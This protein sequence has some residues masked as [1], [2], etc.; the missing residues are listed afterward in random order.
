MQ[1]DPRHV[2]FITFNC[3]IAFFRLFL[4]NKT[5]QPFSSPWP[6]LPSLPMTSLQGT[7]DKD[8]TDNIQSNNLFKPTLLA[9]AWKNI[10]VLKS[11]PKEL[12]NY[13]FPPGSVWYID[14]D[15]SCSHHLSPVIWQTRQ[16][17]SLIV[18]QAV[19]DK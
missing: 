7:R 1:L 4:D 15:H 3:L 6:I 11:T 10:L 19:F 5:L 17:M 13:L 14:I 8:I 12:L 18:T 2:S 9:L 16:Q